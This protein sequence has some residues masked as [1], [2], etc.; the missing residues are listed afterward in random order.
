MISHYH[1]L[2]PVWNN[3]NE[4]AA[5]IATVKNAVSVHLGLGEDDYVMV[6]E[7][8]CAEEGC[9]PLETV[10]AVMRKDRHKQAYKIHKPIGDITAAD[11]QGLFAKS[12]PSNS[13]QQELS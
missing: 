1:Y 9:P 4:R 11:L 8:R 12:L 6:T 10:I 5:A 13:T 7:L 3:S 2:M